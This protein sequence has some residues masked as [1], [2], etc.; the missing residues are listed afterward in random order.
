MKLELANISWSKIEL[1]MNAG[2]FFSDFNIAGH[3]HGYLHV[4]MY[5]VKDFFEF[6]MV[7]YF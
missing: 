7:K 2:L 1:K 3:R 5:D 4:N 6:A